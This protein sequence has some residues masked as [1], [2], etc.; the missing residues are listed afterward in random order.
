MRRLTQPLFALVLSGLPSAASATPVVDALSQCLVASTK[1]EDRLMMV[2]WMT[3]AFAAHPAVAGAITVDTALL[4]QTDKSMAT[5]FER[6]LLTDCRT[7]ARAAYAEA[8]SAAVGL[9]FEALG[10]VAAQDVMGDP[11]VSVAMG[12]FIRHVDLVRL[13]EVFQ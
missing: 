4:E 13:G 10:S 11:D 3:F 7:E 9:A 1:P 2:R 12:G 5:L 6:L 8:G